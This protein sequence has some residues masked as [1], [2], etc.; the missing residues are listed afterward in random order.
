MEVFSSKGIIAVRYP[1]LI[2]SWMTIQLR[3]LLFGS[4]LLVLHALP[5]LAQPVAV[6]EKAV[7][8]RVGTSTITRADILYKI[9]I[10]QAYDSAT[11]PETAALVSV[12]QD[13]IEREVAK[14]VGVDATE[15]E[16]AELSRFADENSRASEILQRVKAVF[17]EDQAGYARLYLS[18]KIVNR[19][20]RHY[21]S[22]STR[23]HRAE[24]TRIEQV[25]L[26]VNAGNTLA[27]A[28]KSTGLTMLRQELEIKAIEFPTELKRY[29]PQNQTVPENPLFAMLNQ[30]Q[31]GAINPSIIEDDNGYRVLRLITR[32]D[33]RYTI[34]TIG[35]SKPPFE[36]WFVQRVKTLHI[37]IDD[38]TLRRD[39][40]QT[41]PD[42]SW[43]GQLK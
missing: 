22:T 42:I 31:P 34:E 20:L 11:L 32:D 35:V 4:V 43:L 33:T 8:A 40:R 16:I 39:V 9:Q 17:G 29:Q 30:M 27:E 26:L 13:A 38:A 1:W 18:N 10:E 28:A 7:V 5:T 25:L 2:V 3:I 41:Y 24:R 6:N 36:D 23:I 12:M 19:K 21:Y 37:E 14:K 15:T